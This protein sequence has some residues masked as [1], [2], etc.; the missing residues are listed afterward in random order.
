MGTVTINWEL[1]LVG[2][3]SLFVAI[4]GLI[5]SKKNRSAS[6]HQ[7]EKLEEWQQQH[8]ECHEELSTQYVCV[9][10]KLDNIQHILN[11]EK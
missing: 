3:A 1:L 4:K 5:D 2:G 8:I 11:G 10:R 9:D 6:E 7:I